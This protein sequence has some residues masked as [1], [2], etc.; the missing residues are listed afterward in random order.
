MVFWA[1]AGKTL[2][3]I[4]QA[5]QEI[6]DRCAAQ[7]LHL[8][9]INIPA[10]LLGDEWSEVVKDQDTVS[11]LRSCL[12]KPEHLDFVDELFARMNQVYRI[13]N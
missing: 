2:S 13:G 7:N 12:M 5:S 1:P 3:A 9:L 11:C 6:F 10:R 8:A 4:S